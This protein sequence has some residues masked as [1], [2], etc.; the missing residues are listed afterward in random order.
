MMGPPANRNG[1]VIRLRSRAR[2]ASP[3]TKTFAKELKGQ[4]VLVQRLA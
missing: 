1:A 2:L 3:S 4:A